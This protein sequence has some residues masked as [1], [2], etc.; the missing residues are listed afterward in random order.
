MSVKKEVIAKYIIPWLEK[1]EVTISP[2]L[3]IEFTSPDVKSRVLLSE[4]NESNLMLRPQFLYDEEAVEYGEEKIHLIETT[5]KVRIVQRN[6]EEEKKLYEYL[7][8]L[9]PSFC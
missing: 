4:L 9:H 7:R 8:T 1:Y 2:K 3:N 6:K 5:D